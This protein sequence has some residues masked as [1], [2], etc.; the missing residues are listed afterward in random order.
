MRLWR[1]T[2]TSTT[3]SPVHTLLF[4]LPSL[5]YSSRPLLCPP[6]VKTLRSAE[7]PTPLPLSRHYFNTTTSNA[8]TLR[9]A[10]KPGRSVEEYHH[11]AISFRGRE[12][13]LNRNFWPVN[14]TPHL[15]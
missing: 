13:A 5:S 1:T 3:F 15:L 14:T 6:I 7:Y 2:A 12:M 4:P 11:T 9:A 8:S 10:R